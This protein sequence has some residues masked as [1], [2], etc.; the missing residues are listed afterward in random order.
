MFN[1]P[2]ADRLMIRELIDSYGDAVARRDGDAWSAC[3]DTDAVWRIGGREICGRSAILSTWI[4]AMASY[5]D[6]VFL[7]FPGAITVEG[8]QASVRTHTYEHLIP[9]NGESRI[10]AGVYEDRVVRRDGRWYFLNRSFTS[11]EIKA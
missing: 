1:G 2:D 10:Q 5:S 4:G 3:W 11:R 8:D 9:V 7:A 6:L